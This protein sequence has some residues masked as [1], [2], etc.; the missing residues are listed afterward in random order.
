[1]LFFAMNVV[2]AL[3]LM[4]IRSRFDYKKNRSDFIM[5]LIVLG[6]F[7]TVYVKGNVSRFLEHLNPWTNAIQIAG[8]FALYPSGQIYP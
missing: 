5:F 1:M 2:T 7:T 6:V 8:L 4:L 3:V